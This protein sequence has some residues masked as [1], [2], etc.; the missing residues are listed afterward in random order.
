MNPWTPAGRAVLLL[1]LWGVA[2]VAW[3]TTA[4]APGYQ[5]HVG[6]VAS[7]LVLTVLVYIPLVALTALLLWRV[8][9][10]GVTRVLTVMAVSGAVG[11][12]TTA[13]LDGRTPSARGWDLLGVLS[14]LAWIGSLP[15][16]PVLFLLFPTGSPALRGWRWVLYAQVGALA[17]LTGLVLVGVDPPPGG[18]PFILAAG[19]GV[20]L[21]AGAAAAAI[22]LLVRWRRAAGEDRA[23][24]RVFA[25]AAGATAGWYLV[26]GL[27]L[28]VGLGI[29][30]L[31][32]AI[33]VPLIFM[34]PVLATGYAVARQHLFGVDPV[35]N[36]VVVWGLVTGVLV[37]G[38][39]AAVALLSSVFAAAQSSRAVAALVAVAVAACLAPVR[40]RAQRLVDRA[41][42]GVRDDPVEMLRAA[43]ARL[44][45]AVDPAGVGLEIVRTAAESLRLPW[46]ALDLEMEGAWARVAETGETSATAPA[47]IAIRDVDEDVG[48]LL[49]APRRGETRLTQRDARLL[50]DLA[51]QAGPAVRAARMVSE[52]SDSRDRQVEARESERRRLRRDLHDSLSPALA[53]IGLS[54]D[55][56][57]R[58]LS[59]EPI[60]ADAMLRRI[61]AEAR[62][63]AEVVRRMLA[64]LRPAALED[65]GLVAALADRASQLARPGDFTVQVRSPA[66]LDTLSEPVQL[67][68]YRIAVE[69]ITNSARHSGGTGC[70]VF[71]DRA[72]GHLRVQITD[73]GHGMPA[74][75]LPGVGLTSMRERAVEVGGR[76]ILDREGPG[77]RVLAELPDSHAN[78]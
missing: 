21:V 4:F 53:G 1:A 38:Y 48:R 39:L 24:L 76:V 35:V 40:S 20:V 12:I 25:V 71:L 59:A 63:S 50:G 75:T 5:P 26:A 73:D 56:A 46:V 42:Y 30:S 33:T 10:H 41:M 22:G 27:G 2:V 69:A 64:D 23:Q 60:Q 28:V 18:V 78:R 55:T 16:L 19:A 34:A 13:L 31:V 74:D 57:R 15:M 37:A 43:G 70:D 11:L 51:T 8:P 29:P 14:A 66:D 67:A 3:A 47:V 52:L 32:G 45:A 36:R 72:H 58:L 61:S 49:A 77:L 68:A 54:A 65:A 62:D 9:A 44:S 6:T 7:E 17:V